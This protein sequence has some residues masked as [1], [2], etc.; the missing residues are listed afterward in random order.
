MTGTPQPVIRGDWLAHALLRRLIEAPRRP[1][2]AQLPDQ[3]AQPVAAID[4]AASQAQPMPPSVAA[5]ARLYE[6]DVS[7]DIAAAELGLDSREFAARLI[8]L[9]REYDTAARRVIQGLLPRDELIGLQAAVSEAWEAASMT[10]PAANGS[11][12]GGAPP[13]RLSLWTEKDIYPPGALV[14]VSARTSSD[15]YLTLISV[16]PAGKATVV[17]PND[18][19]Q[20]NLLKAGAEITVPGANAGYQFRVGERGPETIVGICT[21][22]R[23]I[24]AGIRLDYE[25]QR[26][27]SLGNWRAF[28]NGSLADID[29]VQRTIVQALSPRRRRQVQRMRVEEKLEAL[30]PEHHARTAIKLEV[31]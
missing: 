4:A 5:L 12:T 11:F 9:P 20:V 22:T 13:L 24:A 10:A 28:L 2:Q 27:K 14:A 30:R 17:F 19:E 31:R 18:L 23:K 6:R 7:S 25:R 21:V 3:A 16:N 8:T 26:F 1:A 29:A 15:C